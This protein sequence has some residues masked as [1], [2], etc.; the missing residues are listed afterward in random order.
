M[1]QGAYGMNQ[2]VINSVLPKLAPLI[3]KAGGAEGVIDVYT[4]MVSWRA[5]RAR[6]STVM[7]FLRTLYRAPGVA[8]N[9]PAVPLHMP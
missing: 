2:T 4:G 9:Q 1:E 8:P 6:A 5:A 3:A 7:S